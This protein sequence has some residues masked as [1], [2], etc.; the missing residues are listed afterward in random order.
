MPRW[1]P[2]SHNRRSTYELAEVRRIVD[3]ILAERH[4]ETVKLPAVDLLG[5]LLAARDAEN[6]SDCLSDSDVAN[7]VLL[8]PLA[9]RETTAVRGLSESP[10][11]RG[12]QL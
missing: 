12:T 8:F 4:S 11:N 10:P 5:L 7:Q 2:T 1:L 6:A 9:G 3:E